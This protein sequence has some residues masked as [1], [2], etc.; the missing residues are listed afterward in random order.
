MLPALTERGKGRKSTKF[1][2]PRMPKWRNLR[3]SSREA[4][5]GDKVV[6]AQ[7]GSH[8]LPSCHPVCACREDR[9][10]SAHILELFK[11]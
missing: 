1:P 4:E 2:S 5:D 10:G 3:L 9:T 7:L 11:A 6:V 8:P